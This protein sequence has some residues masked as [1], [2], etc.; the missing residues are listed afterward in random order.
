M[1]HHSH[2][3]ASIL[4]K[5]LHESKEN[6]VQVTNLAEKRELSKKLE[7]RDKAILALQ[8]ES[9]VIIRKNQDLE[10]KCARMSKS[11]NRDLADQAPEVKELREYL[12]MQSRAIAK[13]KDDFGVSK[14]Q[15]K[16]V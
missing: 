2:D 1:E 3:M 13:L 7:E 15:A 12:E 5:C 6:S 9:N 10:A 8:Q 11:K 14:C 16:L 4:D